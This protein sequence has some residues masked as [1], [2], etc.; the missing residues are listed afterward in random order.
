MHWFDDFVKLI[1]VVLLIGVWAS[2]GFRYW[3]IKHEEN[4]VLPASFCM[5]AGPLCFVD[6]P[7]LGERLIQGLAFLVLLV[8]EG[9]K[10][11]RTKRHIVR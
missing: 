8:W 1:L 3:Y 7:R 2:V 5:V 6:W 11:F 10:L 9:K 4:E